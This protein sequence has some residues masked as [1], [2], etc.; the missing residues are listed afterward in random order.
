[1]TAWIQLRVCKSRL[2]WHVRRDHDVRK[3]FV[4][5]RGLYTCYTCDVHWWRP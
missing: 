5:T 4:G 2:Y 3:R 1:M